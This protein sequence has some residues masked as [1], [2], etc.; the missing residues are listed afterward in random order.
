MDFPSKSSFTILGVSARCKEPLRRSAAAATKPPWRCWGRCSG[1]RGRVN[2]SHN[3]VPPP[4]WAPWDVVDYFKERVTCIYSG[5][6]VP[7]KQNPLD[8][9]PQAQAHLKTALFAP[10]FHMYNGS[11][12]PLGSGYHKALGMLEMFSLWFWTPLR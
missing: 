10:G 12:Q 2:G 4:D 7:P 1:K 5:L 9:N 6:D 11:A 3:L 8:E